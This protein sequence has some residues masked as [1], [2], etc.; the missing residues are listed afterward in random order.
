MASKKFKGILTKTII[1]GYGQKLLKGQEV[2][3]YRRKQYDEDNYWTGKWEFH[4]NN[5][6]NTILIRVEEF[7]LEQKN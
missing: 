2:I 7:L 1:N 6:D 3:V 5:K 4:Y